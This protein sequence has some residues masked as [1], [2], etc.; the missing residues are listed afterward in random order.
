[1]AANQ[2]YAQTREV[3]L[4]VFSQEN[5]SF[6]QSKVQSLLSN[7]QENWLVWVGALAMLIG[8]GYLVQVIGSHI[9]FSPFM[10]VSFAFVI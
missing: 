4:D 6:L 5:E 3:Q 8:G 9:Q 7:I 2:G 10:R 1:S